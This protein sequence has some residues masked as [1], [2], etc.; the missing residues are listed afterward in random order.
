VAVQD[1]VCRDH[2][3]LVRIALNRS[4]TVPEMRLR[5][6]KSGIRTSVVVYSEITDSAAFREAF[7]FGECLVPVNVGIAHQSV[8]GLSHSKRINVWKIPGIL[9]RRRKQT[10]DG[11]HHPRR[12]TSKGE[13]PHC[14]LHLP[15]H[16]WQRR[17]HQDQ[18]GKGT[19][20]WRKLISKWLNTHTATNTTRDIQRARQ[21]IRSSGGITGAAA[22]SFFRLRAKPR[23]SASNRSPRKP[24]CDF[25][26]STTG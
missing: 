12:R 8:S 25:S 1:H 20:K 14:T 5:D 24:G 4:L 16:F 10:T 15:E 17:K 2:Y 18:K 22:D 23:T 13:C 9:A 6:E 11:E 26:A 21:C 19:L 7:H 3:P